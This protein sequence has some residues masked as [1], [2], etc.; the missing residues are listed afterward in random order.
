MAAK[1]SNASDVIGMELDITVKSGKGLVAKDGSG[2]FKLG[3]AKTSDPYVV[4]TVDPQGKGKKVKIRETQM[5]KKTLDPEWNETFK[6]QAEGR[7]FK[8][9]SDLVF[10]IF[11]RDRGSSDDPMGE[12]RFPLS[13]LFDGQVRDSSFEVKN[14]SGCKDASGTLQLSVSCAVRRSLALEKGNTMRIDSGILAVG[15]GWDMLQGNRAID[16]DTSCVCVAFDG[17]IMME[18]PRPLIEL[19][20]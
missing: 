5:C 10:T 18:G 14:C 11:D 13:S 12:V 3:K 19:A 1:A 6:W 9:A 2:L 17:R 15:L 7:Q 4:I 16:L 8:P 20:T